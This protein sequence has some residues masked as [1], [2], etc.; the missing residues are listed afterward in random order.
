MKT[1][2]LCPKCK[3]VL[4][5]GG[6]VIFSTRNKKNEVG[7]ILLHQELG[8]Y[9]V[10]KDADYNYE[11]G[12]YLE[13]FCPICHK[14]LSAGGK[15]NLVRIL[16]VDENKTFNI[17][18]SQIAGEKSTYK[19]TGDSVEAFGEHK[20]KYFNF[21]NSFNDYPYKNIKI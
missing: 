17:L 12:E 7:L 9:K 18:F 1:N 21:I 19:I 5:I 2:Y 4:N 13:F 6:N 20:K 8:N 15:E 10:I 3:G 16:M 14:N 11:E